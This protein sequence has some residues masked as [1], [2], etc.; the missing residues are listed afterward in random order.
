[1]D[2]KQKIENANKE[3]AHRLSSGD[4][5]LVDIAPAGEVIPGLEGKM[6]THAGPPIEWGR[7]CGAQQGAVIGMVIYEGWA[8]SEKKPGRSSDRVKFHWNLTITTQQLVRWLA[9][10][11]L[12]LRYGWLR[13]AP[14]ETERSAAK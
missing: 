4:P 14:L 3:A 2:I 7:M 13:I 6:I 9:P 5:V 12:Q 10:S 11:R 8:E 1:M